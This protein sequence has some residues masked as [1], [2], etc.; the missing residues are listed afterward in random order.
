MVVRRTVLKAIAGTSVAT[1]FAGK[2]TC[3]SAV[4]ADAAPLRVRR[5]LH[6]MKMDDPDLSAY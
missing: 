5:N 2:L 6:G 4:A 3:L 1:V